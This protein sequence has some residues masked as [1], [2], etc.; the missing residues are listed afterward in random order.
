M[1]QPEILEVFQILDQLDKIKIEDVPK[2]LIDQE[3]HV[4]SHG[5]KEE[6]ISKN[7]KDLENQNQKCMYRVQWIPMIQ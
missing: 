2:E 1:N 5:M 3:V 4:L 6:E 7:K